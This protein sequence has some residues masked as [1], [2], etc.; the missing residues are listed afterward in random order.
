MEASKQVVMSQ[1]LSHLKAIASQYNHPEAT[2]LM[3]PSQKN[4]TPTS[5][6][7]P[8]PMLPSQCHIA[9]SKEMVDN[10]ILY[11]LTLSVKLENREK[12]KV[13]KYRK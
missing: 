7:Y 4:K 11:A 10:S 8:V 5:C 1:V 12:Y 9:E 6:S 2:I 3:L 13:K